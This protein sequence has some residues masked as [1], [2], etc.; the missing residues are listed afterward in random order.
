M[1][2][3]GNPYTPSFVRSS[4]SHEFEAFWRSIRGGALVPSR[5]DFHPSKARRF[6]RDIVLMEA[7]SAVCPTLRIRLTGQRFDET[8]GFDIAGRDH[9]EF[10]PQEFHAGVLATARAMVA[11]PCGLWQITP[12]HLVRGYALNLEITGFPLLGTEQDRAFIITH[13][14]ATGGV[15]SA[16]MPVRNG[17]SL[18]TAVA[19]Q[20][21]DIGAGVPKQTAHA[22]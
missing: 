6:L 1:A 21:I 12:A 7:P 22:A 17:L 14:R 4:E 11:K 2:D 9:L 20:L 10:M 5:T 13:V 15:M 18:D 8:I 19:Y 3:S 16:T